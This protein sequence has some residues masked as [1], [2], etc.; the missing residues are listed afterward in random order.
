MKIKEQY[1]Y[2]IPTWA[3]CALVNGDESGLEEED[4][5]D[6]NLFLKREHYVTCWDVARNEKTDEPS[7]PYFCT[8]PDLGLAGDVIDVIGY[9][10]E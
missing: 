5:H 10:Y 9:V 4:L 3:L 8:S 2:Q 6:L 7:E 1:E